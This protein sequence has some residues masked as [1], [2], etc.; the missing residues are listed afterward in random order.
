MVDLRL[1]VGDRAGDVTVVT[2]EGEVDMATA[3][4][5]RERL[6][7][8]VADGRRTII[9]DL[10]K[11]DF[12]DSTGLGVLIG[13]MRRLRSADGDLIVVVTQPRI[14]KVFEIT[15]LDRAFRM[16]DSVDD[17]LAPG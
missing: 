1:E 2:V 9:V 5:L 7:A 12:L 4:T 13:A 15:G 10:E 3:P 16:H 14:R 11:V 17:A 6:H 8:L